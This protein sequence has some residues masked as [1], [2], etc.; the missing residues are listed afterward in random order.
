LLVGFVEGS[1]DPSFLAIAS[2]EWGLNDLTLQSSGWW[3]LD[4]D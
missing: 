2:D 4:G 1:I 3:N